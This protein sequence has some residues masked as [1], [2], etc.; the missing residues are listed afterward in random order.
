MFIFHFFDQQKK[1]CR[2]TWNRS[3]AQL[4]RVTGAVK[5]LVAGGRWYQNEGMS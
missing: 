1:G 5:G 4:E 2:S 3:L